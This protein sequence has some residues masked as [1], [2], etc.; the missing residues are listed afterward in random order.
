[1]SVAVLIPWRGG[2]WHRAAALGWVLARYVELGC[3]V[4]VGNH[5]EGPWRKALA[6]RTALERTDA[7][8][9]VVADADC[10]S[11]GV[12]EAVERV[13]AGA[14]WAVPHRGVYRLTRAG[15][16]AWLAG[17]RWADLTDAPLAEAPYRGVEGGGVTVIRREAYERCPLDPRFAGWSG[18]DEAF[19]WALRTLYGPPWRPMGYAPCVH[20]WHPSQER[21]TRARGSRESWDLRK[22]YARALNDPAAVTALLEEVTG[23]P[24]LTC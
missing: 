17:E 11:G 7:D 10:W 6:V 3:P 16:V 22:R 15:T 20:L 1:M 14:A 21:A 2:C 4:V 18:E 19:G 8:V 9:L 23:W 12:L 24:L 13:E 5:A